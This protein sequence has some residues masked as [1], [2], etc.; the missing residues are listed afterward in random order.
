[1]RFLLILLF[2]IITFGQSV[3]NVKKIISL[4]PDP[5]LKGNVLNGTTF[6][7]SINL[8]LEIKKDENENINYLRFNKKGKYWFDDQI[9]VTDSVL[10]ILKDFKSIENKTINCHSNTLKLD[11]EFR[12]EYLKE[13]S[14]Y[15][16]E[17]IYHI[18]QSFR[19]GYR[20]ELDLEY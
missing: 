12:F 14:I 17:I 16:L 11:G 5:L 10:R 8:I 19:F 13:K 20:Y 18:N 3:F 7:D 9:S 4:D 1:M 15:V 2:P 6:T